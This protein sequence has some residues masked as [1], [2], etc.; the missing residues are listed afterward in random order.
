MKNNTKAQVEFSDL[1][2]PSSETPIFYYFFTLILMCYRERNVGNFWQWTSQFVYHHQ[3]QR[4]GCAM[5]AYIRVRLSTT[6][7]Y[8]RFDGDNSTEI[9][10]SDLEH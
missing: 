9:N 7:K 10:I 1:I 3:H 4:I 8:S 5:N 6:K 2:G